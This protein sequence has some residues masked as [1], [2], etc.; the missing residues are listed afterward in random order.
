M[1]VPENCIFGIYCTVPLIIHNI[2]AWLLY[3]CI[4][5]DH[6]NLTCFTVLHLSILNWSFENC[7]RFNLIVSLTYEAVKVQNNYVWI[8]GFGERSNSS[9]TSCSQYYP[10]HVALC[11]PSISSFSANQRR[12]ATSYSQIYWGK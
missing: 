3:C 7:E 5:S 9:S 10:L 8:T 11:G 4:F 1:F 12:F 2:F 6:S